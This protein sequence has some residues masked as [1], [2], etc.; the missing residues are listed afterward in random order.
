MDD[1]ILVAIV[2]VTFAAAMILI[3]SGWLK[4]RDGQAAKSAV[5]AV[6]L[7]FARAIVPLVSVT[8]LAIGIF[9]LLRPTALALTAISA[10]YLGFGGF[11][12]Y[13]LVRRIAIEDCGCAGSEV[14]S[15]SWAHVAG[16]ALAAIASMTLIAMHP[17]LDG[18]PM[19]AFRL[20]FSGLVWLLGVV[21]LSTLAVHLVTSLPRLLR[22]LEILGVALS[23][24]E[25]G[26]S[27]EE[28][29]ELDSI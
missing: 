7:P 25:H 1:F 18:A 20:G 16:N 26:N 29:L 24:Q 13:V 17:D 15:P 14:L 6:G 11:V 3:A 23:G 10:I 4:L 12:A 27:K 19:I 9:V 5:T 2:D 22:S 21:M 28:S 8:E